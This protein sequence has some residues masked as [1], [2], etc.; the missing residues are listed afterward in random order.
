DPVATL[1]RLEELGIT[2]VGYGVE[3]LPFFLAREAPVELEH[4]VDSPAEAA[5]IA[6]AARRLGVDAAVVLCNPI[7]AG[8]ALDPDELLAATHRAEERMREGG[9]GGKDVTPFLLAA[10]ADETQG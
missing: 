10:L 1:E 8:H 2:V 6:D 3:R 9:V 5:A 4:R 7:A